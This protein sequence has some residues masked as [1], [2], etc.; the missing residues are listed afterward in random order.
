[1]KPFN[2]IGVRF[3][4]E[5]L[6]DFLI[7]CDYWGEYPQRGSEG[8]PHSQMVDIWARFKDPQYSLDTGDWSVFLDEHES[9]WLKDIPEV[10]GICEKLMEVTCGDR[11]GG[12]L[13]TKLPPGG[14]ITPHIDSGWHATFYDKYM[15]P[16]RNKP[17]SKFCFED[18]YIEPEEGQ[19]FGFRNDVLHWVENDSD[20]DRI[21]MIVCIHQSKF[22][23]GGAL[24]LGEQQQ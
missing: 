10:K 1:M 20:E 15:V 11:L 7:S 14:K 24:C 12:V 17:G 8:S 21:A 23:K 6:G 19:V 9:I 5:E 3:D 4:V 2:D 18:G 16:I 13:I 22:S